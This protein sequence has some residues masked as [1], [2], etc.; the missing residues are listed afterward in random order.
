MKWKVEEISR[1][2]GKMR[3]E[4]KESEEIIRE[5][6]GEEEEEKRK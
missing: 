6:S 3:G 4:R 2:E 5:R 1:K